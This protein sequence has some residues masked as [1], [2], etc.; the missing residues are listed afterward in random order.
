M[1]NSPNRLDLDFSITDRKGRQEFLNSYIDR[2]EFKKKPLNSDELEMCANYILWGKD[3]EGKNVVQRKE[4]QIDTKNKTWSASKEESLEALLESPTFNENQ[5]LGDRVPTKIVREVFSREQ[6]LQSAPSDIKEDFIKLFDAIDELELLLNYYDLF[7]GKRDK[8]P[9]EDL[10]ARFPQEQVAALEQ[11][12]KTLKQ[13]SYLKLRHQLVDLRREQYSLKDSYT[14]VQQCDTTQQMPLEKIVVDFDAEAQVFPMGVKDASAARTLVFQEEEKLIPTNFTEEE[15]DLLTHYYWSCK[16]EEQKN[17]ESRNLT[18]FDF[19]NEEHVY[20]LLLFLED[21]EDA[22]LSE[23]F[24]CYTQLLVDTLNFYVQMA[25]FDEVQEEIFN[26]KVHKVKNQDVAA[27]INEKYGKTYSAN[28]ISTIFKQKIV[29]K[30]CEAAK[31]HERLIQSLSIPEEF[32]KCNTC[33]RLLLLDSRN[34]VKKTRSKDGFVSRCKECDKLDRKLK[35][36][37]KK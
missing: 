15:L 37:E 11:E 2:P 6:A 9:R 3:E 17:F 24:D 10:I 13:Y 29:V 36:G 5:I 31:Y 8:P 32:K 27:T 14:Q 23:R 35:K 16:D 25:D 18:Y 26:F 20:Q 34:F 19:R 7:H 4:I 30:I 22:A 1:A 33:G 12:A 28:Y 21:I